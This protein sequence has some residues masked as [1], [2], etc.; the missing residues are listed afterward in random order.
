MQ[1]K[2]SLPLVAAVLAACTLLGCN[3]SGSNTDL[4]KEKD[5]QLRNNLSRA[6]TADEVAKMGGGKK[7]ATSGVQPPTKK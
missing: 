4:P 1:I 7:D 2:A 6:L 3:N 5:A